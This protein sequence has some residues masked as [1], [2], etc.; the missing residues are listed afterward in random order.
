MSFSYQRQLK[1]I[2]NMALKTK[3]TRILLFLFFIITIINALKDT[4]CSVE[5]LNG[6]TKCVTASDSILFNNS[7]AL[8]TCRPIA[9]CLI[10]NSLN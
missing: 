10:I 5:T 8:F 7:T 6:C 9:N 1:I 4:T 3:L 2:I